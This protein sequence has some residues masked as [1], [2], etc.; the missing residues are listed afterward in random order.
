MDSSGTDGSGR[1][2]PSESAMLAR[3]LRMNP[4]E[5]EIPAAVPANSL[6]A[7]TDNV[8]IALV[9]AH[10]YTTGLRFDLVIRLR[11]EPRGPLAYRVF[12]LLGSHPALDGS[13][14]RLLLGV[15]FADGRTVTNLRRPRF[16]GFSAEV[17]PD[18]LSLS[19]MGGGGGGRS[20]DQSFWLTPLPPAG[21]LIV[22][23]AWSAFD[24]PESRTELDGGAVVSAASEA[25]VLWPPSPPED[26]GQFVPEDPRVPDGGWFARVNRAGRGPL[27]PG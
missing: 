23:C 11:H 25:A 27:S 6:L 2:D 21:P 8:A 1:D 22:V 3:T 17:D 4:P 19:P 13:E 24:I 18:E 9:G 15:E 5:N 12:D 10:A 14:E 7:R 26:E 20:F 16:G